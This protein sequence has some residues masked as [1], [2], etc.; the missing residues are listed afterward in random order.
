M[1]SAEGAACAGGDTAAISGPAVPVN[2][3]P[4]AR[5]LADVRAGLSRPQKELPPTYFYD[6]RGSALFDEITRL[7]E[8]YL[9]RAEEALLRAHAPVLARALRPR[10]V[11]ELGAGS[12]RKARLLLSAA[13]GAGGGEWYVPID[14]SAAALRETTARLRGEFPGVHVHPTL[15]DMREAIVLPPGV[16]RP[17]LFAFLGSTIGNF[18]HE[19]AVALLARIRAALAPGDRLLLG[20]DL[21]KDVATLEAAYDDARGVTA[22][23]NRN[24]LRVLNRELGADFD[25]E[26][27]AHRALYDAAH[28]RI[29]MHLVA[30]DAQQVCIPDVGVVALAA[31]ESI[32]TEVSCKY[33]RAALEGMLGA[34]GLEL[35][36]WMPD[37]P[38]RFALVLAAPRG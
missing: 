37:D 8:Y 6:A 13:R 26:A 14:V 10:T 25:V 12:A 35:E 27:F 17:L 33:D 7:P 30:R 9:T 18:P 19:D 5:M 15:G 16:P 24:V 31:G 38:A 1:C 4:R 11:A 34:A 21:V 3:A 22:E 28:R 32:R 23:F 36:R 29:E 2:P 20:A